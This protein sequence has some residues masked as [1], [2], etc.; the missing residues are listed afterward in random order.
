MKRS[1]SRPQKPSG[2][3]R[4]IVRLHPGRRNQRTNWRPDIL[5][6][7]RT[8]VPLDEFLRDFLTVEPSVE[9]S[10]VPLEL[11]NRRSLVAML[12]LSQNNRFFRDLPAPHSTS[13]PAGRRTNV[14]HI[15]LPES[16]RPAC[17]TDASLVALEF[18]AAPSSCRPVR[19]CNRTPRGLAHLGASDCTMP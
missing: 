15:N 12:L 18:R 4:A 1:R 3:S 13:F 6:L 2:T 16:H 7:L 9:N 14:A 10:V 19:A 11:R 8:A 5:E 17:W